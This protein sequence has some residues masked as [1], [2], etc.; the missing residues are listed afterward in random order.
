[1][2]KYVIHLLMGQYA[3]SDPGPGFFSPDL[4]CHS[5]GSVPTQ[6]VTDSYQSLIACFTSTLKPRGQLHFHGSHTD[7]GHGSIYGNCQ[8][9]LA[10][11]GVWGGGMLEK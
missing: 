7:I 6:Y 8:G 5:P 9:S 2:L 3:S 4:S 1:M 11:G 10:D